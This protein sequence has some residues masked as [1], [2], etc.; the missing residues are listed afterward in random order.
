MFYLRSFF[1]IVGKYPVRGILLILF[2]VALVLA[3]SLPATWENSVGNVLGKD[4]D[5]A[6]FH[7]LLAGDKNHQRISRKLREL[8]GVERVEV[9]GKEIVAKKVRRLLS[10]IDLDIDS[11]LMDM[12]YSGL[13]V[14]FSRGLEKRSQELIRD[15]LERLVGK[16]SVTLGVTR[17]SNSLWDKVN[18]K[19]RFISKWGPYPVM[20]AM[21]LLWLAGFFSFNKELKKEAY[22]I[23]TYQRRKAVQIKMAMSGVALFMGAGAALSHVLLELTLFS[24]GVVALG[25]FIVWISGRSIYRWQ[26]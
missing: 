13:K 25:L 1:N 21:L 11:E 16:S 20:A 22:L 23:E 8:P 6:Y 2:S 4:D 18:Q 17:Q 9:L 3:A 7:A 15:Y 26:H 24:V 10:G 5:G 14:V 12:N 19:I